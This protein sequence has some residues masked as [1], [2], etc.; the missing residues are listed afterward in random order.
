MH[1]AFNS[2]Y[3]V[4][5]AEEEDREGE[6]IL[7]Y[8]IK[9]RGYM[10]PRWTRGL[11]LREQPKAQ[12][13][14]D[15]P[16]QMVLGSAFAAGFVMDALAE[17][18]FPPDHPPNKNPLSWGG[19]YSEFPPALVARMRLPSPPAPSPSQRPGEGNP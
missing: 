7:S 15:R 9:M 19:R 16:L 3:A 8:S 1:P 6:M 14:F 12:V 2:S 4:R 10:T 13:Y 17:R 18:A 11:A 5:M